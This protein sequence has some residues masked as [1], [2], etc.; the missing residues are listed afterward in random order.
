MATITKLS[1]TENQSWQESHFVA[2]NKLK[3]CEI[4]LI[5]R[6]QPN[7]EQRKNNRDKSEFLLQ[8]IN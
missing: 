5:L 3:R 8:P 1:A 7:S 2:I 4:I 6:R